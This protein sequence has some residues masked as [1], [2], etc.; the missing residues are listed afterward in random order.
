VQSRLDIPFGALGPRADGAPCQGVKGVDGEGN[1]KG[2]QFPADYEVW[3]SIVK[4][5]SA[6]SGA[7]TAKNGFG[8]F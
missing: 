2:F 7:E 3:E 8:A 4:A 5:P 1:G 6:G